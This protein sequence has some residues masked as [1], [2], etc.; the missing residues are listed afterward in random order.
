LL[1]LYYSASVVLVGA[2][3]TKVLKEHTER[4]RVHPNG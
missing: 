4:G 3:F 2:D 1:W